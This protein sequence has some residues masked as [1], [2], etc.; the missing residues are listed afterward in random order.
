MS[1]ECEHCEREFE[2][3]AGKNRHAGQVHRTVWDDPKLLYELY[4]EEGLSATR[5]GE[6]LG[7][8]RH[9]ILEKLR[10][11]QQSEEYQ[12]NVSQVPHHDFERLSP[13]VGHEYER[14]R[15]GIDYRV[16]K[17]YIHRL[18]AYANGELGHG[19]LFNYDKVVHHKSNHGLDNRHDN[20]EV[21]G[22]SEHST[23][24]HS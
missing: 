21:M 14:V 8:S 20:L 22:R 13:S 2:T 5:I 3:Q 1:Y 11:F 12:Y 6:K 16:Y 18:I 10:E 7:C 9:A 4:V 17:I 24:H 15:I 19:D 23:L